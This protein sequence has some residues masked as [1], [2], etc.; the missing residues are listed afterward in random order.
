MFDKIQSLYKIKNLGL[1]VHNFHIPETFNE[2]CEIIRS[3]NGAP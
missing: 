3:S 1:N 2:Y